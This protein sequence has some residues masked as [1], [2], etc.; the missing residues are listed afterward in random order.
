MNS[1][2]DYVDNLFVGYE[3]SKETMDLKD[4][5]LSNLEAKVNDLTSK[6]MNYNEALKV[7]E[8]SIKSVDYLID[9]NKKIYFNRYKIEFIQVALLYSIIGC[10]ITIPLRIIFMGTMINSFLL[11]VSVILCIIFLVLNSKKRSTYMDKVTIYNIKSIL[12]YKKLGWIFWWMFILVSTLSKIA[13]E[14]GSNIWF[15]TPITISGPYQFAVLVLRYA[16]PFISIIIPLLLSK[17]S[18][19]I[20]KYEAGDLSES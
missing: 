9:G 4:E 17:S 19:L 20:L 6:G 11:V 8:E 18:K 3:D 5:I 14:F 1:L 10:I 2:K 16:L 13:V 12:R 15:S 7:S